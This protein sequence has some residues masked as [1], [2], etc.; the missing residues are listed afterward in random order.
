MGYY[1]DTVVT[2]HHT[3]IRSALLPALTAPLPDDGPLPQQLQLLDG[4]EAGGSKTFTGRVFAGALRV[5]IT[6]IVDWFTTLPW[7]DADGAVL[8]A[9]WHAR[10]PFTGGDSFD[11]TGADR[12]AD[13]L[14]PSTPAAQRLDRQWAEVLDLLANLQDLGAGVLVRPL[15][16]G[17]AVSP[18]LVIEES[19]LGELADAIRA[20][21]DRV[22]A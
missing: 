6:R 15:L 1:V 17:V 20:G 22:G 19:E 18:P 5:D 10:N 7:D 16:K 8:T 11:R 3:G 13:L 4:S 12:L 14:D 9:S 2:L 21:L